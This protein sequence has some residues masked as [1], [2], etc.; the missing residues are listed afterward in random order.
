MKPAPQCSP[1]K[2]QFE[3]FLKNLNNWV[4]GNSFVQRSVSEDRGPG[5]I[6]SE[7]PQKLINI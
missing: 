3:V 6:S 4:D 5:N 7:L 2:V 1:K